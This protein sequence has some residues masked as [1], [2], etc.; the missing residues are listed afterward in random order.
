MDPYAILGLPRDCTRQQVKEAYRSLVHVVHPDRG[1]DGEAF[2][3]LCAAYREVLGELD[4]KGEATA[5]GPRAGAPARGTA[6][7]SAIGADRE[8]YIQW[9]RQVAEGSARRRP[10]PWWRKHPELAR[11]W[12][13]GLIGLCGVAV[14]WAAV[15]LGMKSP[16]E[17]IRRGS[18]AARGSAARG[19]PDRRQEPTPPSDRTDR[20]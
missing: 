8:D 5:E 6:A 16:G 15:A 18:G 3:R 17:P 10:T 13:L 11:A 9:L 2:L 1:G 12:L 14:L 19:G 20:L 4:R 7:S